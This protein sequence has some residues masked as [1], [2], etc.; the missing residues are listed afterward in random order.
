MLNQQGQPTVYYGD[1]KQEQKQKGAYY[2]DQRL[3]DYIVDQTVEKEFMT[4]YDQLKNTI[5]RNES[6]SL[7]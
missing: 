2:T 7:V 3:V 6:K 4:R 1:D 5:Q